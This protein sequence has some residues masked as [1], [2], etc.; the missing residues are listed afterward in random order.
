MGF[1]HHP[2]TLQPLGDSCIGARTSVP[3]PTFPSTTTTTTASTSLTEEV[4]VQESTVGRWYLAASMESCS[5]TCQRNGK[6]C[7]QRAWYTHGH[8][9]DTYS[10]ISALVNQITGLNRSL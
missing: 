4:E 6:Q 10:K 3:V 8:E 5:R 2:G 1:A 7:N 9:A